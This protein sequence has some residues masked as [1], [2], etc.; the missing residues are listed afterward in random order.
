MK[1]WL[2]RIGLGVLVLTLGLGIGFYVYTLDFYRADTSALRQYE[3]NG[4]VS[5]RI[6]SF[7]DDDANTG[8]IIYPGGK[9]ESRAYALLASRFQARGLSV[10][11]AEMP[12]NL[13]V[14]DIHAGNQIRQENEAIE[15]WFIMGHSLG[16]AMA[17]SHI[18]SQPDAYRGII[19]LAA[20]PINDS[21]L[22]RLI[23]YGDQDGVLSLERLEAYQTEAIVIEGGNHANFAN[24]GDQEGDQV[25]SLS[26][27]QQQILTLELVIKFIE[28][29][30]MQCRVNPK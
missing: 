15:Q 27:E 10:F 1:K 24:Y 20:Y 26:T 21:S 4:V 14:F 6:H 7:I 9:V 5:N 18:A 28:E 3:N 19:Y 22:P 16:G 8:L 30:C 2:K 25:S 17:S 23:I 29:T 11:I 13:A 12:F